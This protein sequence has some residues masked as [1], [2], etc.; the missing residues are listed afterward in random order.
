[1]ICFRRVIRV[2]AVRPFSPRVGAETKRLTMP[3]NADT[4]APTKNRLL[5]ML[6]QEE[7]ERILP[8]LGHVSFSLGQVV[9]ESGGRVDY[10]YFPTTAI[11][12]LLYTMENGS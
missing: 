12:S 1:M 9:Y 4:P 3:A 10:I 5:A 8:H 2:E 7:Y 11:V 6:P